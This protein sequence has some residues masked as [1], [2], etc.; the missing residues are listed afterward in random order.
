MKGGQGT[1]REKAMQAEKEAEKGKKRSRWLYD[2]I[3]LLGIG[4]LGFAGFGLYGRYA[5]RAASEQLYKVLNEQYVLPPE[6]VLTGE[7]GS[8]SGTE[9]GGSLPG[10]VSG[11]DFPAEEEEPEETPWNHMIRVNFKSLKERNPDVIDWIFFENERI[12]YPIL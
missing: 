7:A 12:S 4:L 9:G 11:G 3:I 1:R 2:G 10:G 6:Q 5:D 8:G